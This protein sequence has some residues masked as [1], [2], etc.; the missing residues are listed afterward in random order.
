[1]IRSSVSANWHFLF[2]NWLLPSQRPGYKDTIS[3][4]D[5]ISKGWLLG[6]PERHFLVTKLAKTLGEDLYL[7]RAKIEFTTA[8]FLK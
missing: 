7:K 3:L 6:P 5:Y 4:D 8:R 1:M 2:A